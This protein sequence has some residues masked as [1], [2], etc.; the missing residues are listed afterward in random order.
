MRETRLWFP[1]K[2]NAPDFSGLPDIPNFV[3]DEGN[4]L[5]YT[6]PDV[7]WALDCVPDIN[8]EFVTIIVYSDDDVLI[9]Q[10]VSIPGVQ[11]L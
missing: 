7:S 10:L 11:V 6:K 2:N 4:I 5:S 1:W 3:D 9:Q 8:D